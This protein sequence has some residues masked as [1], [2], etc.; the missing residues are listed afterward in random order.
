MYRSAFL[1]GSKRGR[2]PFRRQAEVLAPDTLDVAHIASASFRPPA[3]ALAIRRVQS[4]HVIS[5][6]GGQP[7]RP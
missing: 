6:L 2:P 3:E 7:T 4:Q 1:D 5:N